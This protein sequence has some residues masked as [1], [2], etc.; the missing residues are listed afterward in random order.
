M[1]KKG[2]GE[3]TCLRLFNGRDGEVKFS[4]ELWFMKNFMI[5]RKQALCINASG[6]T[7]CKHFRI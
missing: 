3:E 2:L 4:R 5:L 6:L 1:F 7:S